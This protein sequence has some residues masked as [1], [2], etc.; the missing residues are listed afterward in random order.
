MAVT[1]QADGEGGRVETA[2]A[3]TRRRRRSLVIAA[4]IAAVAVAVFGAIASRRLMVHPPQYAQVIAVRALNRR[5]RMPRE[6]CTSEEVRHL[7]PELAP[8]EPAGKPAGRDARA[9]DTYTTTEEH[10]ATVSEVEE[11]PQGYE[12]RY[13]LDGVAGTVHMD[14]AP[15][16]RILLRDG[17]LVRESA[18]AAAPALPER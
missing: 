9:D 8:R 3:G 18:G 7:R 5:V 17:Q 1:P 12:V 16:A 10:C 2:G 15:G 14:H 4:V 6:L 11:E 13:R